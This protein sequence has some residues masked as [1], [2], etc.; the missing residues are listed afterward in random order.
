MIKKIAKWWKN[1]IRGG[2]I[3][4]KRVKEILLSR[5][6]AG[7]NFFVRL[8]KLLSWSSLILAGFL[9]FI[10]PLIPMKYSLDIEGVIR[11]TQNFELVKFILVNVADDND[12]V[13]LNVN[14]PGGEV[15]YGMTIINAIEN[16]KAHTISVNKG[17]AFS[18]GSLIAFSTDEI[19]S[20]KY[21]VYLFH[22]PFRLSFT[23]LFSGG[24]I[25]S[26]KTD[27]AYILTH[28]LLAEKVFPYLTEKEISNYLNKVDVNIS[29]T[30]LLS[31]KKND[32]IRPESV[33]LKEVKLTDVEIEG[34]DIDVYKTSGMPFLEP[35]T[36]QGE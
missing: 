36:V 2:K 13:T 9:Y 12:V 18:M 30:D 33:I 7:K 28:E 34:L 16:S 21:A 4:A 3:K 5:A 31:R 20:D 24:K 23:R 11:P 35:T 27:P 25:F 1:K 14:S 8:I 6:L 19:R 17:M 22:R 26:P 32:N 15:Y 10:F 29:A